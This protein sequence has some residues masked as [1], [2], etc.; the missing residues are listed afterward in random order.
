[1]TTKVSKRLRFEILRRDGHACR[2]CGAAAPDVTLTVDHVIPQALGGSSEPENLV[3]ACMPCN[4]G[5]TSTTPDAPLVADVAADAARWGRAMAYVA[6][7]DEAD[8]DARIERR[9]EFEGE[10]NDWTF[11]GPGG[12]RAPIELPGDWGLTVD[13]FGAAGLTKG[14][15]ADAVEIAMAAQHVRADKTWTY[16]CGVCWNKVRA[17]QK[18]AAEVLAADELDARRK[19]RGAAG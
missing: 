19:G 17:R 11:S 13:R 9:E 8:R 18:A 4:S 3:A 12:T 2:Y 7:L 10:W 6:S 1:M 15:L 5:K 16:F 14:D